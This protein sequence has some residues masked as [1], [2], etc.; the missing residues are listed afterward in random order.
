[1]EWPLAPAGRSLA[2]HLADSRPTRLSSPWSPCPCPRHTRWR[3]AA[4]SSGRS[5]LTGAL[6]AHP[7][8]CT[9][10]LCGGYVE[11]VVP[12]PRE[13]AGATPC[14]HAHACATLLC[15][16]PVP[17][18]GAM[19]RTSPLPAPLPP[20]CER[21]HCVYAWSA[22]RLASKKQHVSLS[23][24]LVASTQ[25]DSAPPVCLRRSYMPQGAMMWR[26]RAR[27]RSVR[28]GEGQVRSLPHEVGL[29]RSRR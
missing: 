25:A 26:R 7:P 1:M 8:P 12:R 23:C 9:A 3:S 18:P 19:L 14:L 24:A 20:H 5:P 2:H 27:S 11:G 28:S 21:V 22:R 16:P 13:R 4:A 17:N 15:H 6:A 29:R 10:T